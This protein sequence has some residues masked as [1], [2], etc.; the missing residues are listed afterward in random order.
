MWNQWRSDRLDMGDMFNV[1][2]MLRN[3]LEQSQE[4][5]REDAVHFLATI[6]QLTPF[7]ENDLIPE[8]SFFRPKRGLRAAQMR[9]KSRSVETFW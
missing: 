3:E 2:S 8:K 1:S 4:N 9:A 7:I 5:R 6:D